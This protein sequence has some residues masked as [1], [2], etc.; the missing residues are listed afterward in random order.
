MPPTKTL[1]V[2]EKELQTL[3]ATPAGRAELLEL[4]ARYYAAGARLRPEK[5]S[6]ITYILVYE[7]EQGQIVG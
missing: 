3:I 7:R 5:A 1:V 4:E 2:R 6:L